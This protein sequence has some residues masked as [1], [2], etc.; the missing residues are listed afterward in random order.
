VR[1]YWL[2]EPRS[3]LLANALEGAPDVVVVGGGVTGCSAALTL[4]RAGRKVRLFEARE[5]AAGA[6][7]RNGGFALRGGAAP[8]DVIA[9]SVGRDRAAEFWRATER[10]LEELCSLAGDA[11]RRLGSLRLANDAE[12]RD[13]L[14]RE[15][16]AMRADGFEVEW[17]EG[18][19]VGGPVAGRFTGAIFHPSDAVLQP[20]RWVRRLGALAARAGV[21]IREFSRVASLDEVDT[22]VVVVATDGYP[23]GLLGEL[24]GLIVPTRGQMIATEPLEERWFE[25][26]HYGRHGYDYWHQTSDGRILAGG[27]RDVSMDSEFTAVEETTPAVQD[28]LEAFVA[29]LAGRPVRVDYRWAGIFGLV[30]DFLPVV[31]RVPGDGRLWTAGGYSGHG[32]VLGFMCGQLVARAILDDRDPLLDICE[33]AR[34]LG[35]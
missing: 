20:A 18:G 15:F 3:P 19:D 28:A 22:P 5:I 35:T 23:S 13:E 27:F 30:L 21:E 25:V 16:E 4:A 24:E 9:E 10:A 6:S 31:G 8:Y 2:A 29:E 26:P 7:G 33:P 32:N 11:A 12:E 1:S 34:L 17:R 14:R